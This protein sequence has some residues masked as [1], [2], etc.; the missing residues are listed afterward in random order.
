MFS[1]RTEW[2]LSPNRLTSLL[3][4]LRS[5]GETVL[6]LTE[7]NPTLCG[8]T[9][10]AEFV[11]L[12]AALPYDPDP[13]GIISARQAIS[14][15]YGE[16]R[17]GVDPESI[18][19]TGSTSEAYSF[20]FRLLCNP[21]DHVLVPRPS[22]PLVDILAA[23]N[24][25]EVDKYDLNYDGEWHIDSASL[26]KAVNSRTR[27]IVL[28][29]PSNPAGSFVKQEERKFLTRIAGRLGIPLIIDE[30][31]HSYTVDPW[32]DAPGTFAGTSNIPQVVLNGLSKLAG[33]PQFKLAWMSISGPDLWCSAA[34]DRLEMIADTFLSVPTA[35]QAALPGILSNIRSFSNPIQSR[36]KDNYSFLRSVPMGN[37]AVLRCEGGWNAILRVPT[38][39]TDEEWSLALLEENN[40]L[41]HPGYLF[42]MTNGS[43][44]VLSLLPSSTVFASAVQHIARFFTANPR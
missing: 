8:L 33:L 26:E 9:P 5:R 21:A 39:R 22:Y 12:A 32:R 3:R 15:Y 27:A 18:L 23:L 31:F 28:V 41:V 24:D 4:R 25:V 19:L 10:P 6:D 42:D 7:S 38:T 30:V 17:A 20:L 34:L 11:E 37:C 43:Y 1:T 36:I 35:S 14:D 16:Q 2:N 13:K 44:L 40:V 29:H